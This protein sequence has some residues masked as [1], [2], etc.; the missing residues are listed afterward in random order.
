M[1]SV[2]LL[3]KFFFVVTVECL[4]RPHEQPSLLQDLL[5]SGLSLQQPMV[6][7]FILFC[8]EIGVQYVD[9]AGLEA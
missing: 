1:A 3:A 2:R 4:E 7:N 9:Q 8:F 6:D 5:V